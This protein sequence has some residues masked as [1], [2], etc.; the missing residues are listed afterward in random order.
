MKKYS[1]FKTIG[2]TILVA[3]ILTWIFPITYFGYDIVEEARE[4]I[5]IFD[6]ISMGPTTFYYFGNLIFYI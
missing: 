3:V 1:L 2:I 4:Q 5:G 6:F